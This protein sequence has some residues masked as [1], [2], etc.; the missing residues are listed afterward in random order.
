MNWFRYTLLLAFIVGCAL[1]AAAQSRTLEVRDGRVYVD[2]KQLKRDQL[3][4]TLDVG[5]VTL[6]YT[7]T[8]NGEPYITIA[9]GVY[10]LKADRLEFVGSAPETRMFFAPAANV[11]MHTARLADLDSLLAGQAMR[12]YDLSGKLV[13]E[14][15]LKSALHEAEVGQLSRQL[16]SE[17]QRMNYVIRQ[18]PLLEHERYVATI[19]ADP[20]HRRRLQRESELERRS[21]ALAAELRRAAEA[22]TKRRLSRELEALLEEI[23]ELK[24]QN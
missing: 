23:F 7:F 16:A 6:S 13:D 20:E 12:V 9:D 4:A 8:G 2:G 24:Q 19:A 5:G 10:Q 1:P 11:R 18:R 15:E 21:L 22:D 3:P 14:A 17:A